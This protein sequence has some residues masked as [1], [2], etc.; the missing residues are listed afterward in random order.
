MGTAFVSSDGGRRTSDGSPRWSR[1][2]VNPY[3]WRVYAE[4]VKCGEGEREPTQGSM[5]SACKEPT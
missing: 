2:A 4:A 1:K 5:F 3:T